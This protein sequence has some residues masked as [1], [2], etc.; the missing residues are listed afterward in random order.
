MGKEQMVRVILVASAVLLMPQPAR[1]AA[2]VPPAYEM[3]ME[4]D[5]SGHQVTV[6]EKVVWTNTHARP[7][8]RLEFNVHSHFSLPEKDVGFMAKMLEILRMDPAE[9][10]EVAEAPCQVSRVTWLDQGS[11]GRGSANTPRGPSS[12]DELPFPRTVA[13]TPSIGDDLPFRWREDMGTALVVGLPREV[14]QGESVTVAIDFTMRLPQK[15]GRWGQW[16]G[17]TFLSNWQPVLAYYD[18]D[19]WQPTPFIPWHQPFFNEA[20]SFAVRAILPADQVLACT[21]SIV[22]H[23]DLPDGRQQV[24]IRAAAAR[25]FA[26]LCSQ[27]Y[28]VYSGNA[29]AVTIKVFAFQE[30]EFYAQRM[31][32]WAAEAIDAYNHWFGPYPFPEFSVAE[33]YFGWNGNQ[34]AGLVMIDERVFGMPHLAEGFVEYLLAHE[35]CH[36]WWYNVV[37][38]N[39]YAETWMEEGLASY[40]SHRLM[41]KKYGKGTPLLKYPRGLEWLP[42]ISRETYRYYGLMGTIG[43]GECSAVIQPIDKFDHIVNLFSMCYDRGSKIVGM[44]EDRLGEAAF[45]EFMR[46]VYSHYS[47]RVLHVADFRREL[48]SFTGRDWGDFFHHWLYCADMTDWAVEKVRL[49]DVD[50]DAAGHSRECRRFRATVILHQKAQYD[51]QTVLGIRLHEG[52]GYDLRLP[53]LPTV[54]HLE[55]EDPPA[56]I[57]AMPDHRMRVEVV[58]P[59]KP[60]QITVDPDQILVDPNF[61]NNSWK[62]EICWRF[63]PLYTPLEETDLTT[64]YDRWNIVA[65]PWVSATVYDDPWYSRSNMIGMRLG[66]YR[67]Q[68]FNGGVYAAYRTDFRDIV[69]GADALLDHWPWPHT[70]VGF[71][72]ERSLTSAFGDDRISDRAVLF[73]RYVFQYGDSLYL[74]PMHFLEAFTALTEN[75]L[76]VPKETLPGA[77]PFN[78]TTSFGLHYRLDYLTPYW[79][80]EGGFRID[81]I[82]ATGVPIEGE[83]QGFNK[84]SAQASTIKSVPDGLGWLSETAV[85]ARIYGA[86]ALPS[87]GQFFSMG[88]SDL[89]RG[90]DLR[91]VEGSDIWVASVE[92]RFP[93][94]QHVTWDCCDHCVGI[95]GINGALFYDVGATYLEGHNLSGVDHALGGGIRFDVAWFSFVERSTI[96]VDVAK[97]INEATPWQ[98]WLGFEVPF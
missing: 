58:L 81:A 6:H 98:I 62:P 50:K 2:P 10:I 52:K 53:I 26:F 41:N 36:Q 90:F 7:T 4:V 25:D 29:G 22:S 74:P 75:V 76:P 16:A 86:A 8:S 1:A 54:A 95:R 51:E 72:A 69:V 70:Q 78:H 34:C 27:R 42:N 32:Q 33:S 66:A 38:T 67:T 28:R 18:D 44:I 79:Y 96:R 30:H 31:V 59:S 97:T 17:V 24:E 89:F 39:G 93:I 19:G 56:V 92:W 57:D 21:G 46:S 13:P 37:G 84:V 43:R 60:L 23:A 77:D 68:F 94:I 45:L 11:A 91:Q 71:N 35:T 14:R 88:G 3:D 12:G 83:K 20:G 64:A 63:T 73:G 85:A 55:L 61:A 82:Y 40:F 9:V 49:D 47:F 87:N 80:P 5:V 15:Q 48:E 65:G